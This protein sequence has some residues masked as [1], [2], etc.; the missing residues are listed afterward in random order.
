M[1][2]RRGRFRGGSQVLRPGRW[3]VL[4]LCDLVGGVEY[5]LRDDST[6][7]QIL[8]RQCIQSEATGT[9]WENS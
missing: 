5:R 7:P 6:Y 3:L 9:F 1:S 4:W 8:P 2:L